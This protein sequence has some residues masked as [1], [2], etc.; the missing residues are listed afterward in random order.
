VGG[1]GL[2]QAVGDRGFEGGKVG[3]VV[4]IPALFLDELPEPFDQIEIRRVGGQEAQFDLQ[5]GGGSQ[6]Q[7]A[8][9]ITGVVEKHAD[10][11]TQAERRPLVQQDADR[12]GGDVRVVGDRDP[13]MGDCI[14]PFNVILT[15]CKI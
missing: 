11:C 5:L 6:D 15:Y 10:G 14:S 2:A 9:L 7:G 3:V 13:F 4:G 1:V 8:F 12:F